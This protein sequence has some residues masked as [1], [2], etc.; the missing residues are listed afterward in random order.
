MKK[1]LKILGGLFGLALVL[2]L[3]DAWLTYF[4][5]PEWEPL[6]ISDSPDGRFSVSVYSNVP[7][8]FFGDPWGYRGTVV[9][10]ENK[11]GK[12]LQ[13]ERSVS[14]DAGTE[15]P[16]VRWHSDSVS[17][18]SVDVWDLPSEEPGK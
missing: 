5:V 9:L 6:Y 16:H 7:S 17:V 3:L 1:A 4:H 18:I 12:V 8:P 15:T 11:S 14:V 2:M 10:R 13:R